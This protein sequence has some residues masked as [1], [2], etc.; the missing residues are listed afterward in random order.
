MDRAMAPG[1]ST[2]AVAVAVARS[3]VG[4]LKHGIHQTI[5]RLLHRYR[6][7]RDREIQLHLFPGGWFEGEKKS[8]F[9]RFTDTHTHAHTQGMQFIGCFVSAYIDAAV[10][11]LEGDEPRLTC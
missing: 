9:I 10:R 3:M 2:V 4:Y 6:H 5:H 7:E 1:G 8:K 11:R